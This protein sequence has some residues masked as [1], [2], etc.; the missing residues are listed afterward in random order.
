MHETAYSVI[1]E[2][3]STQQA[4]HDR[5]D[6]PNIF[7]VIGSSA[8]QRPN[9]RSTNGSTATHCPSFIVRILWTMPRCRWIVCPWGIGCDPLLPGLESMS[10]GL[11]TDGSSTRRQEAVSCT[12][13]FIKV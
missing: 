8:F 13:N 5:S 12:F 10:L 4:T 3:V 2:N 1:V 6:E 7:G 11:N 9:G